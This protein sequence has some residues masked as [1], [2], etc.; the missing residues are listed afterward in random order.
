MS[1]K[2]IEQAIAQ[3]SPSDVAELAQWFE[4]YQEQ[5][6]DQQIEEDVKAGKFSKLVEQAREDYEAGRSKP[7]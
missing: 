2:E 5:V 3:L 6:W 4:E 1:I 7:L